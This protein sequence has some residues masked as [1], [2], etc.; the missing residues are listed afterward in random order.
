MHSPLLI[1][2]AT[3]LRS[4]LS[5]A[6]A[7]A[8]ISDNDVII[9]SD[10]KPSE[11]PSVAKCVYIND[12]LARE[13]GFFNSSPIIAKTPIAWDKAIYYLLNECRD[14]DY[15][16]IMEDDVFFTNPHICIEDRKSVV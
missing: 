14:L 13:S 9:I 8:D 1:L 15:V 2:T 11:V 12:A 10:N 3:P 7:L 6:D 16:W 4:T 5:F